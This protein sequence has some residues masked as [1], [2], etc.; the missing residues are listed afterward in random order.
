MYL[1]ARILIAFELELESLIPKIVY[2]YS[3]IVTGDE[4]F[5]FGIRIAWWVVNRLYARDFAS[6]G[7][8]PIRRSH[9]DLGLIFQPIRFVE[10]TQPVETACNSGLA[11]G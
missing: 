5:H 3:R 10:Q 6:L 9:V 11:V 4:Q 1:A 8:L 2:S 7:I